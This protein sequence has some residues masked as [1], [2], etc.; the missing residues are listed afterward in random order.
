[1]PIKAAEGRV[2]TRLIPD[3]VYGPVITQIYQWRAVKGLGKPT[4]VARLAADPVTYPEPLFGPWS[5]ALVD[6]ILSNPKYT[7]HQ[8][9]GRRRRKNGNKVWMP[10]SAWKWSEKPTHTALVDRPTWDAAQDMGRRHGNV[11]DPE[12][13]TSRT[14]R[15]Y[16][17][18]SRVRCDLDT[19]RMTGTGR[20]ST[21]GR[22]LIY[23]HCPHDPSNPRHYAA[24]PGHR[25][26]AVR[27]DHLMAVL[28]QFFADRVFGPDRAALLATA[29]TDP[30]PSQADRARAAKL[31]KELTKIGTAEKSLIQELE[32]P[33]D[34]ADPAAQA[35]RTGIRARHAEL[36][37]QRTDLETQLAT[38]ETP[39]PAQQDDPTLLDELPHL[40]DILTD[41]PADLTEQLLAVFSIQII[42]SREQHQATIHATL[43]DATPQTL[44]ALLTASRI[45]HHTQPVDSPPAN[46]VEFDHLPGD[47]PPDPPGGAS[48]R[49]TIAGLGSAVWLGWR[50]CAGCWRCSFWVD[51]F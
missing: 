30:G 37:K 26:I 28:A 5:L 8:V 36:Y 4:I 27:E 33:A 40:G 50:E 19:R 25:H 45:N 16:K 43:T 21:T 34:P 6:E 12:M 46:T 24:H 42:Y 9:F 13:P 17:L 32:T 39:T 2:K 15:R 10:A 47:A 31:R 29:P 11:R 22:D 18:R 35:L 44:T 20:P 51:C 1:N 3:P 14:G 7:G 48:P 38:L 41:A 23:Y 49:E